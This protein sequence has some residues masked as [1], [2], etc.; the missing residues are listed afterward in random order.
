MMEKVERN[1]TFFYKKSRDTAIAALAE[2]SEHHKR[3]L[4]SITERYLAQLDSLKLRLHQLM[5][6]LN[7]L[8]N[9]LQQDEAEHGRKR[10]KHK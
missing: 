2:P 1:A 10:P 9:K 5:E 6:Q 8:K 7:Q 3:T 4:S